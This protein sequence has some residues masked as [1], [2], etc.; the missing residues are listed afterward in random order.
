MVISVR[1][2]LDAGERHRIVFI[3]LKFAENVIDW[4]SGEDMSSEQLI[5][6]I[7]NELT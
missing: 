4:G 2:R 7:L 1:S 3:V 5:F 6:A